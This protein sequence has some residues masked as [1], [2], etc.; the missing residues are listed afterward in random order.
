LGD[1]VLKPLEVLELYPPHDE[2]LTGLFE[3][4][5]QMGPDRPLLNFIKQHYSWQ[6]FDDE[7]RR[8]AALLS[9]RSIGKG[10]R[11]AI[12]ATNSEAHV[13]LLFALAR[14]GAA[15]VPLNPNFGVPEL[16][17]ILNHAEV[18]GVVSSE[19][20]L[21]TVRTALAE[22][23]LNPWMMLIDGVLN[24]TED[25]FQEVPSEANIPRQGEP[26]DTCLII[27]TSGTT[28]LPKGVMHS[29]RNYVT[30]AEVASA[31]T[32]LQPD[33]KVLVIL[34]FFHVN[35]LFY[36]LGSIFSAGASGT[37]LP[38]FSAS[39]FWDSVVET[40]ATQVNII[41]AVG[42]I[43]QKRPRDEFRPEHKLRVVYGVRAAFAKTFHEEFRIPT[44]VTGF[45]MTECPGVICN[46]LH[47]PEKP[48]SIGILGTHPDISR[49]WT[50]AR[51]TDDN[52]N[53][54]PDGEIGELWLSSPTM[55]QGYFRDEEHTKAAYRG[56]WF[57]TGDLVRR[58]SDGYFYFVSRKKD[59]IRRRGENI[60]GAELDRVIGEH[61]GVY[62]VA[63]I[64]VPAELGEDEILA[65]VVCKTGAQL[66][67]E[68]I[69]R[70][71]REHLAPMKVPRFVLFLDELPH[72]PTHKVAKAALR[73]DPSLR[74]RATDLERQS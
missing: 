15:M 18:R 69:A 42:N 33:D 44:L 56:R 2:T 17:Y 19:A 58:D 38:R 31:R 41:E 62:E 34:P 3:S 8:L 48:G 51:V 21:S 52:G 47:G 67:A 22:A 43:L 57:T 12:V 66:S 68:D 32:G 59:I 73:A 40:Q 24:K 26:D 60:S 70:W 1:T 65:A 46:P 20:A 30:C 14:L 5:A 7:V 50:Q 64:A 25:F 61:P 35:A 54:V 4:R 71:C 9:S 23:N 53:D 10:D 55:M 63:T 29:Q 72:T 13:I 16:K 11:V 37:V 49:P 36:S 45:G 28:G 27:Y 39:S 74:Q 6:S